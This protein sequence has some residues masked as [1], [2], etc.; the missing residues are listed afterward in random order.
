MGSR[1]GADRNRT[2]YSAAVDHA[3][4]IITGYR[5]K[6]PQMLREQVFISYSH[7]DKGWLNRLKKERS[8]HSLY[9]APLKPGNGNMIEAHTS[10]DINGKG[11]VSAVLTGPDRAG[12]SKRTGVIIAHGAGN[13][14][15]NG[16]IVAIAEALAAAGYVTLRFNFPYKERGKKSPDAPATLIHTWQCAYA[17]LE[18]NQRFPVHRIVA[19]GKSMGGRIA[20]QMVAAGQMNAAALIFLGYP[21]HAPGRTEQLRDAHLFEIHVPMLFFAGTKDPFCKMDKLQGVLGRLSGPRDLEI[22]EGG[23]HSFNLP[24][25]STRS[26]AEVYRQIVVKCLQWL[27]PL[28]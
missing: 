14:M 4:E 21:L 17:H 25:S 7:D 5:R 8:R 12:G 28:G 11:P 18:A 6:L 20:A 2:A 9:W 22:V 3:A 16:L 24:K 15:H 1:F 10:I 23:N 13:D 26:A 19:A 27:D